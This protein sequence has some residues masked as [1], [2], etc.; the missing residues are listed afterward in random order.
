MELLRCPYPQGAMKQT[1][2]YTDIS[3]V[4]ANGAI[5]TNIIHFSRRLMPSQSGRVAPSRVVRY[6]AITPGQNSTRTDGQF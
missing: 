3:R 1:T 2:R 5:L 4:D 6:I